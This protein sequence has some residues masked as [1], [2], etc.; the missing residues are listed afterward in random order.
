[1][2]KRIAGSL[3]IAL[4]LFML[5]GWANAD[6]EGAA[7]IVALFIVV[8]L[9]AV[10]GVLLFRAHARGGKAN[11]ARREA[12]R[13]K[14]VRSEMIRLATARG[15]KLTVVEAIAATGHDETTVRQA[16]DALHLSG[17]ARLEL[18]DSGT[19]VWAFDDIATVEQ[20]AAARDVLDA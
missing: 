4:A 20:K 14:T 8:V 17:M 9:P 6:V 12:L 5:L 2:D 19:M 11:L 18:T 13:D 10:G 7:S 3:L 15:G 1:M 16:L